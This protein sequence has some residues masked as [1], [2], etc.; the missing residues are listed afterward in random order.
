[1]I[2]NTVSQYIR[3]MF[4]NSR[5][6]QLTVGEEGA[7]VTYLVEWTCADMEDVIGMCSQLLEQLTELGHHFFELQNGDVVLS[8]ELMAVW[9]AYVESSDDVSVDVDAMVRIGRK[10][11]KAEPLSPEEKVLDNLADLVAR[12]DALSRLPYKRRMP[13]Q[14]QYR[15]HLYAYAV[16]T[17]RPKD[18]LLDAACRFAEEMVLYHY[19]KPMHICRMCRTLF[20]DKTSANCPQCGYT[21]EKGVDY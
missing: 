2:Q 20:Y 16:A 15:A 17:D 18:W 3:T 4:D 13:I 9:S 8:E 14:L 11:S 7:Q 10:K 6:G 21:L 1:M 19:C 12:K 5:N